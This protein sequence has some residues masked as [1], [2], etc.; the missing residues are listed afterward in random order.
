M[1]ANPFAAPSA[2]QV[3]V[4]ANARAAEAEQA[5]AIAAMRARQTAARE[6]VMTL[7]FGVQVPMSRF[8]G[9]SVVPF[10]KNPFVDHPE[11]I[12]KDPNPSSHYGFVKRDD[13]AVRGR[14]RAGTI[15]PVYLDQVIENN[16]AP[17]TVEEVVAPIDNVLTERGPMRLVMWHGLQMIEIPH[18]T[19]MREYEIPALAGPALMA[20]HKKSF[21]NFSM[22]G[23]STQ[24]SV[25]EHGVQTAQQV[26]G[27]NFSDLR[28][29]NVKLDFSIDS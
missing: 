5:A 9:M 18:E 10:Q 21:E 20:A 1:N 7:P 25:D 6:P 2:P 15:L 11:K 27:G 29:K 14:L 24:R 12:L 16:D 26:P 17:I 8:H 4:A 3:N 28:N 13:P 22:S 19:W 23:M